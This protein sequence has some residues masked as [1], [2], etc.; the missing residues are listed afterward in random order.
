MSETKH[1]IK[2]ARM[3]SEGRAFLGFWIKKELKKMLK[4]ACATHGVSQVDVVEFLVSNWLS[5][6]HVKDDIAKIFKEIESWE[7]IKKKD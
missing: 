3:E 4:V 2:R 7:K 6:P 5:K 1:G